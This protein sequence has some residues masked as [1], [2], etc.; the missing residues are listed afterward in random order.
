MRSMFYEATYFNA[1]ISEWDTSKVTDMSYMFRGASSFNQD[2]SEWDTSSVT[3]MSYIFYGA[4]AFC[5][6]L[7]SW[8]QDLLSD[9]YYELCSDTVAITTVL[10]DDNFKDATQSYCSDPLMT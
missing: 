6:D 9:S 4:Y 5:Q 10:T 2:I 3:T 1:D 8:D 7:S